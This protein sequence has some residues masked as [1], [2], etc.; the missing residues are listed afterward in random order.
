LG[1][2]SAV[3][4]DDNGMETFVSGG[5]RDRIQKVLIFMPY[6]DRYRYI[7]RFPISGEAVEQFLVV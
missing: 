4:V 1:K 2:L 3:T 6:I 5:A 7:D